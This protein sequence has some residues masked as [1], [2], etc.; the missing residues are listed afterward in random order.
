MNTN[1]DDWPHAPSSQP[2]SFNVTMSSTGKPLPNDHD[3]ED[4]ERV[5]RGAA[6]RAHQ[7]AVRLQR[8]HDLSDEITEKFEKMVIEKND[9]EKSVEY[10][11]LK[12]NPG[13]F[14][15]STLPVERFHRDAYQRSDVPT[16]TR[17]AG[18]IY[19]PEQTP[20]NEPKVFPH[21][22]MWLVTR[23]NERKP[24]KMKGRQLR[25]P[26]K[27]TGPDQLRPWLGQDLAAVCGSVM[28][29]VGAFS[30]A[31]GLVRGWFAAPGRGYRLRL[32]SMLNT[33]ARWVVRITPLVGATCKSTARSAAVLFGDL[34]F[35]YRRCR[36]CAIDV[37]L[38]V[39][40]RLGS[41]GAL[42]RDALLPATR[43][44]SARDLGR[45]NHRFA[46]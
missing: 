36:A 42:H 15:R 11:K 24:I 8:R 39:S 6:R 31:A 35:V 23:R 13:Y 40:G 27:H 22:R 30:G 16:P 2:R 3:R 43:C 44:R 28:I 7:H 45:W 17:R 21:Q 9:M 10:Q 4:L 38:R 20:D 32:N 12:D 37:L 18:N 46:M 29:S 5:K 33:S 25:E 1:L 19:D 41:D 34:W 26:P 14:S